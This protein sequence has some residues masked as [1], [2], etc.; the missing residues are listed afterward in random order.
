M[1]QV[2]QMETT[3]VEIGTWSA[4]FEPI[5]GRFGDLSAAWGERAV[6]E[7]QKCTIHC[8]SWTY[9]LGSSLA[10][11]GNTGSTLMIDV[12]T[13]LGCLSGICQLND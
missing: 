2:D 7:C 10:D 11:D 12:G 1:G 3:G 6:A 8:D 13:D 5:E 4:V 9:A